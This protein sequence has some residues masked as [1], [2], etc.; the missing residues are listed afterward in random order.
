MGSHAALQRY[1]KHINTFKTH[2]PARLLYGIM[3]STSC[4]VWYRILVHWS[5]DIVPLAEMMTRSRAP[6]LYSDREVGNSAE[7]GYFEPGLDYCLGG[8]RFGFCFGR[9]CMWVQRLW[10]SSCV[11]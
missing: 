8:S 4:L 10:R 2:K 7:V 9:S 3:C 6:S 5:K 1:L 11:W